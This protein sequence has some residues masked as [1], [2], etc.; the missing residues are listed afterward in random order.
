LKTQNHKEAVEEQL[1]WM[2]R[3]T[4]EIEMHVKAMLS[5]QRLILEMELYCDQTN[6]MIFYH[7]ELAIIRT[8]FILREKQGSDE[9]HSLYRLRE[10]LNGQNVKTSNKPINIELEKISEFYRKHEVDINMLIR[11]RDAESHEFKLRKQ[12]QESNSNGVSFNRQLKIVKEARELISKLYFVLFGKDVP[13]ESQFY[14]DIYEK[15]YNHSS[16]IITSEIQ[17]FIK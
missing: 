6:A 15:I 16:E 8:A 17:S 12:V 1:L 14:I 2:Y 4:E 5:I 11:R 3:I 9:K 7:D 13:P 10:F